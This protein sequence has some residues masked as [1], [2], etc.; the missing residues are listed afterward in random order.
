V[1]NMSIIVILLVTIILP[2]TVL[3]Y[4]MGAPDAACAAMTPG[5]Q[6]AAQTD[7]VPSNLTL[8]KSIVRPGDMIELELVTTGEKKFKGFIIQARDEDNKDSQIGSFVV[9]GDEASYMTCGRGIHNSITHRKSNPKF[10]VKAQWRAPANYEGV[11]MFRYT[12]LEKYNK[13]WVGVEGGRVRVTRSIGEDKKLESES[14]KPKKRDV[15]LQNSD[16]KSESSDNDKS[17]NIDDKSQNSDAQSNIDSDRSQNKRP[18]INDTEKIVL[19]PSPKSDS[20][21]PNSITVVD[22]D[23]VTKD[24]LVDFPQR[25]KEEEARPAEQEIE[26][27]QLQASTEEKVVAED[28]TPRYISSTTTL[29]TTTTTT[30]EP[31]PVVHAIN[32]IFQHTDPE[33]PIYSGCNTTKSCFGMPAGCEKT[34]KC[35]LIVAYQPDKEEYRFEMKGLSNGYIAMGLSIDGNMGEDLTTNCVR[36]SNGQIDITTGFNMGYSGNK[37][38]PR[39]PNNEHTD[40]ITDRQQFSIKDGWISCE[41]KRKGRAVVE[42]HIWDL[43]KDQFY[44]MLAQG[45]ATDG[46]LEKHRARIIAGTQRGLGE[47][48]LVKARSRLFIIL[49]GS[50][51]IAAWICTSSLGIM[52]ARYYK[53]TWTASRCCSLD[54]WFVLHRLLMMITWLLTISGVILIFMELKGFSKTFETNPHVLIGFITVGLTFIQPFLALVRCSPNSRHRGWFNWSHWFIG[55]TAQILGIVC[56]FYAVDLTAAQ[57]PRPETDW[58]LVGFV[59]FHFLTHLLMS[60]ITCV[61]ESQSGKSGYPMRSMARNSHHSSYPDYE[62]LKGDAPGSGVRI[63]VLIVYMMVNIIVC[64]ALILLVVMAPTRPTLEQFGILPPTTAV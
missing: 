39:G 40:G 64:A 43:E 46:K 42:D 34:K 33:D 1:I 62:E 2:T 23:D 30:Q 12:A 59:A 5:H 13:F 38:I 17:Q 15:N 7:L 6:H 57:L 58:L 14:D 26:V 18:P 35:Q 55:N 3:S 25:D 36:Q 53:Q 54:Q 8:S 49:H 48:G 63:F 44:V 52:I 9:S 47:V 32:G 10:S 19:V 16:N 27:I 11:V 41:W 21:S 28:Q 24:V 20:E 60:C 61:S 31:K 51:M 37:Y 29:R 45:S 22:K 56:I 50:F 4:S